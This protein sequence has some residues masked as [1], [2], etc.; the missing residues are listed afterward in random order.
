MKPTNRPSPAFT[1]I[2]LLVVIAIIAILAALLLPALA[3]AKEKALRT[4]CLN[5]VRNLA[6]ASQMYATDNNDYL[7]N[8]AGASNAFFFGSTLMPYLATKLNIDAGAPPTTYEL[9]TNYYAKVGVFQCPSFPKT[10]PGMKLFL[11][12]TM[13][14]VDFGAYASS[15][16][17]QCA[18]WRKLSSFPPNHAG[19][20]L[21]VE[22]G[23]GAYDPVHYDVWREESFTFDHRGYP[24]AH[25]LTRMIAFDDKRHMGSTVVSF[26]DTHVEVRKIHKRQL[27]LRIFNPLDTTVT[28]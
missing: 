18:G 12:Y 28:D 19:I 26:V 4:K 16:T 22:V 25:D 5:N 23:E 13:A 3:R 6:Q 14:N 24:N 1:L 9:G 8:M 21:I 10:L 11:H 15:K 20:G 2:E 17:Y 27:S 7:P